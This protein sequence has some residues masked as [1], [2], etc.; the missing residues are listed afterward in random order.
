MIYM[1]TWDELIQEMD[2]ENQKEIE[3]IRERAA[4]V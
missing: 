4:M 1:K 3:A 2:P